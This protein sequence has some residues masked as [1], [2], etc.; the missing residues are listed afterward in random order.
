MAKTYLELE[1]GDALFLKGEFSEA[2]GV[3]E[4]EPAELESWLEPSYP[5]EPASASVRSLKTGSKYQ[6]TEKM[7][8]LTY[9]E[10]LEDLLEVLKKAQAYHTKQIGGLQKDIRRTQ[11]A[12]DK[13]SKE[14]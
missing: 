7:V 8:F 3:I 6:V 12:L 1:P 9:R 11:R 5:G 4:P 10:A 13:A 2:L 14:T